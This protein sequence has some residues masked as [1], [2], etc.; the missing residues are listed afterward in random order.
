MKNKNRNRRHKAVIYSEWFGASR[1]DR[2]KS[3]VVRCCSVVDTTLVSELRQQLDD[4]TAQLA[5]ERQSK[6][7]LDSKY[8]TLT[9]EHEILSK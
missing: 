6:L 4:V 9:N 7:A 2:C 5:A 3:T 1:I 8:Q